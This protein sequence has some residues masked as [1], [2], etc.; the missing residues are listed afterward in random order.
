VNA[1]DLTGADPV[2]AVELEQAAAQTVKRLLPAADPDWTA[3]PGIRRL[4]AF[5]E[6]KTVWH[7]LGN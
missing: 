7:P 5:L 3:D 2:Q 4:S 1:L 6:T